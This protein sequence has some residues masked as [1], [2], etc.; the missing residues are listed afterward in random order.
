MGSRWVIPAPAPAR[1]RPAGTR[2][3]RRLP[4]GRRRTG[5]ASTAAG[6]GGGCGR[7]AGPAGR[8][9]RTRPG[10]V[11]RSGPGAARPLDGGEIVVLDASAS[12]HR[13]SSV[14]GR[15]APG[16]GQGG[17]ALPQQPLPLGQFA[18]FAHEPEH[19]LTDAEFVQ[20]RP[21]RA[22]LAPRRPLPQ[23]PGVAARHQVVQQA[24]RSASP[25]P[26]APVPPPAGRRG[27]RPPTPPG[28][29]EGLPR[30]V[31]PAGGCLS[32][33]VTARRTARSTGPVCW[34]GHPASGPPCRKIAP[35][36]EAAGGWT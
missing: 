12:S 17:V 3:F 11:S 24:P 22:A 10:A 27:R 25:V 32:L 34:P 4:H 29:G 31:P 33:G 2:R 9:A 19:R 5:A 15:L 28:A 26:R 36:A 6:T 8:T 35:R 1:S 16:G 30:P 18:A 23:I 20:A 13:S 21:T 7:A 14:R